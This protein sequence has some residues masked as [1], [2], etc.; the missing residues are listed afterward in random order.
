M[1]IYV[2]N[3]MA[4]QVSGTSVNTSLPMAPGKHYIVAKGWDG[5][6]NS[7]FVGQYVT[8]P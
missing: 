2:D 4:Y 8:V 7:W 6:G 5:A 1:Q 3:A